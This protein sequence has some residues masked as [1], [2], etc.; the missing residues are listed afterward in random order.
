MANISKPALES[1]F[2][3]IEAPAA[4]AGVEGS[5]SFLRCHALHCMT[6]GRLVCKTFEVRTD[7]S[8]DRCE[9]SLK[10]RQ[11]VSGRIYF[12]HIL[13]VRLQG[14]F[15][16]NRSNIT[17]AQEVEQLGNEAPHCSL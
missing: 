3:G 10:N 12:V 11:L 9:G 16:C 7:Q 2:V 17:S 6:N 8:S 15:F 13:S 14:Q 4:L 5:G 1:P